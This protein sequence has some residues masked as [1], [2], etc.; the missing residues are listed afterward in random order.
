M[1]APVTD[2]VRSRPASTVS[3][4]GQLEQ[5]SDVKSSTSTG[6][7]LA[8]VFAGDGAL[9]TVMGAA[10]SAEPSG[11]I[12]LTAAVAHATLAI[13]TPQMTS[14]CLFIDASRSVD[15]SREKDTG[16]GRA[17]FARRLRY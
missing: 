2:C 17:G 4:G 7:A 1:R 13:P 10:A 3:A 5:P 11:L 16:E 14:S 12:R 8:S 9:V 15:T 6:T